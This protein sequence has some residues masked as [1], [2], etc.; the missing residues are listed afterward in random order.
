MTHQVIMH[1][2][3]VN[4]G[5]SRRHDLLEKIKLIKE[6]NGKLKKQGVS[7]HDKANIDS[8]QDIDNLIKV[9]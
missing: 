5:I 6:A 1:D 3:Y 2:E 7:N 4:K 8:E 9:L